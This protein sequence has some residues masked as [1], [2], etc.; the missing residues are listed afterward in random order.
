MVTGHKT[1]AGIGLS[2]IQQM[3]LLASFGGTFL[4]M[5]GMLDHQS[6]DLPTL[7]PMA[8][9]FC[10]RP[11]ATGQK[12]KLAIPRTEAEDAIFAR[13][14]ELDGK[15]IRSEKRWQQQFPI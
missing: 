8:R 5:L 10:R 11:C 9:E 6:V 12:N 14:P 3:N 15:A 13:L 7:H 2:P 4:R 1:A